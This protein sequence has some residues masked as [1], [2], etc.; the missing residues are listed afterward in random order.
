MGK[1]RKGRLAAIVSGICV[2]ALAVLVAVRWEQV[3]FWW[4][5]YR[6]VWMPPGTISAP[7]GNGGRLIDAAGTVL[8]SI[9][10][11]AG[12]YS[13]GR[14]SPATGEVSH[15]DRSGWNDAWWA[16][17]MGRKGAILGYQLDDPDGES[18]TQGTGFLWT[19]DK[20]RVD[21]GRSSIPGG[22]NGEGLVV[23][24]RIIR[25]CRAFTWTPGAGLKDLPPYSS[26]DESNAVAINEHGWVVGNCQGRPLLWKP[27]A[28]PV[29]LVR[30]A[31]LPST[32]I[33]GVACAINDRGEVLVNYER[34]G[35]KAGGRSIYLHLPVLWTEEGGFRELPFPPD[36]SDDQMG[37][38]VNNGG[39]V[40]VQVTG[41]GAK[42]WTG[43]GY[44]VDH[45]RRIELP[46]PPG[47][48]S[49]TYAAI[50]DKG[51][52]VGKAARTRID[53]GIEREEQ[54]GFLIVPIR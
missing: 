2:L 39:T 41:D 37:V 40:L 33:S 3:Y 34:E 26:F 12:R 32:F 9:Q 24:N 17:G 28:A 25:P 15:L 54:R 36:S 10:D 22:Q 5:G 46:A 44:L 27:G 13:I 4:H 30:P 1:S 29:N 48:R 45:G 43:R 50:T 49:V 42:G 18:L 16:L 51:W 8:V 20:G 53:G 11:E 6:I 21:L 35:Q 7:W 19:E 23:G 47:W 52:I 31:R 38:A 14:W